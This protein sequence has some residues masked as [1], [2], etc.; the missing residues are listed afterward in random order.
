MFS[1][2][3]FALKELMEALHRTEHK[4]DILIERTRKEDGLFT[5]S[6][7]KRVGNTCP[8]CNKRVTYNPGV[9]EEVGVEIN[10]LFRTCGC[11]PKL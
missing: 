6:P 5:V 3:R 4:L 9:I 10:V 11:S 7:M 2:L 1:K 8:V